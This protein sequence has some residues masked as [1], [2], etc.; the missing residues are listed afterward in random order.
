[1]S[2]K[3]S[4]LSLINYK[5]QVINHPLHCNIDN[6]NLANYWGASMYIS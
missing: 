3:L 2:F 1:M 4:E 6:I 5:N